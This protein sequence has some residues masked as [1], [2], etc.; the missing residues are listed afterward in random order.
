MRTALV[1]LVSLPDLPDTKIEE[2]QEE[3]EER[4]NTY[5]ETTGVDL[6]PEE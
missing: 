2:L 1:S 4:L 5:R 6:Y 3:L